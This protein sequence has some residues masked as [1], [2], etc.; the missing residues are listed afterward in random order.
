VAISW[1]VS[2]VSAETTFALLTTSREMW[3]V[4]VLW[5]PGFLVIGTRWYIGTLVASTCYLSSPA[6]AWYS[7]RRMYVDTLF[8]AFKPAETIQPPDLSYL[9]WYQREAREKVPLCHERV[10]GALTVIPTGGGKTN[11]AGAISWDHRLRGSKVLFLA[12]TI[13]LTLQA[14]ESMRKMGLTCTIEQAD[15]RA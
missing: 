10:R 4:A 3:T 7:D 15:N 2:P 8:H 1:M 14:Y 11:I 6:T 13:T 9:R 5:R 12:P